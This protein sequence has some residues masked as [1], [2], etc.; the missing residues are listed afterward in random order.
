MP[1]A[2]RLIVNADD[3]GL[4]AG[5]NRGVLEAD[6]TGGVSSVSALVNAP[7]WTD[8]AQRLRDLSS[9][10]FPAL[11]VGL[12]VNLTTGRPPSCGGSLCD[13]RTAQPHPPATFGGRARAG[14]TAPP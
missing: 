1:D 10:S 2:R 4:S 5:V 11:G 14:H 9:P 12:H 6:E 3:F 7:G 13:A 8:A